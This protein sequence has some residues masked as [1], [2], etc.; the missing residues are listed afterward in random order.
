M[1]VSHRPGH[2]AR[3]FC[4]LSIDKGRLTGQ[5]HTGADEFTGAQLRDFAFLGPC[6]H[7]SSNRHRDLCNL[8][9]AGKNFV[10]F[11]SG[12]RFAQLQQFQKLPPLIGNQMQKTCVPSQL[13][14]WVSAVVSILIIQN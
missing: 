8:I 2:M 10:S 4:K 11:L 6:R 3:V 9:S 12:L 14:I 5:Y 7:G 1:D 13:L